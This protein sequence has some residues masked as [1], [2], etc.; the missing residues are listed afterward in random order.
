MPKVT[1]IT[2]IMDSYI[3]SNN[4][5]E[6]AEQ[7]FNPLT[8]YGFGELVRTEGVD[9][10]RIWRSVHGIT[11][12]YPTGNVGYSPLAELNIDKPVHW[13]LVSSTNRYSI[14]DTSQSTQT[15]NLGSIQYVLGNGLP[16]FNLISILNITNAKEVICSVKNNANIEIFNETK[17][18]V[19]N[20]GIN[21]LWRWLFWPRNSKKSVVFLDLTPLEGCTVTITI[22]GSTPETEVGAGL[23]VIGNSIG[24]DERLGVTSVDYGATTSGRDFSIRQEDEFTGDYRFK[25]GLNTVDGKFTFFIKKEL[26]DLWN[27]TYKSIGPEPFL[28]TA[29]NLFDSTNIFGIFGKSDASITHPTH[30]RVDVEIKGLV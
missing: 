6:S 1:K 23:Y 5:V 3:L 10:H 18:M 9:E 12:T 22:N 13:S 30:C 21:N 7:I 24:F 19:S 2:P 14:F 17:Q 25:R 15:K 20:A 16:R 8:I 26:Y 11:A 28:F 27:E 29:T 4:V